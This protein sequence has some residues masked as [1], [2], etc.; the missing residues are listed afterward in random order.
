MI[1]KTFNESDNLIR[2][3]KNNTLIFEGDIGASET[4]MDLFKAGYLK[5]PEIK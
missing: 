4:L 1:N 2:F 3:F 5:V